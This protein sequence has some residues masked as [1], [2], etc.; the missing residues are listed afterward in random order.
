MANVLSIPAHAAPPLPY[1][2][3]AAVSAQAAGVSCDERERISKILADA[4]QSCFF[5]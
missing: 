1:L 2:R 3:S 5:N 4:I